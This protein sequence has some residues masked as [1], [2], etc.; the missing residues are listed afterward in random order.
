MAFLSTMSKGKTMNLK[1]VRIE[2]V[3]AITTLA[4]STIW[5]K[6][7]QRKFPAPLKV[8]SNVSV[9]KLDD[10]QAWIDSLTTS[11]VEAIK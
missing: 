5:L 4:K 11:T 8:S 10:I 7:A 3:S 6:V 1:L 2:E 9:W